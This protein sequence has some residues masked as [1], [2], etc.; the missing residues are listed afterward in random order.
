MIR[1]AGA[2]ARCEAFVVDA[3]GRNVEVNRFF[4]LGRV[5]GGRDVMQRTK[6]A[7]TTKKSGNLDRVKGGAFNADVKN[8]SILN[9]G[10]VNSV[11]V[12]SNT[13]SHVK[14]RVP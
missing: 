13:R 3:T 6:T 8:N 7:V 14:T 12:G 1:T 4:G 9:I 2:A 11:V 5:W 10:S